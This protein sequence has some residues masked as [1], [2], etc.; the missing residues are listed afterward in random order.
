MARRDSIKISGHRGKAIGLWRIRHGSVEHLEGEIVGYERT[1]D[2]II[3]FISQDGLF[4]RC[5]MG[6]D[7]GCWMHAWVG[8]KPDQPKMD[9]LPKAMPRKR[10][11][12]TP[13]FDYDV[14]G[15]TEF[16]LQFMAENIQKK[17]GPGRPPKADS[18]ENAPID[19]RFGM[20]ER[21]DDLFDLTA[22]VSLGIGLEDG[23]YDNLHFEV[24]EL[25]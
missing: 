4:Q 23:D 1:A 24:A 14:E 2:G 6:T 11:D 20:D 18:E 21:P 17:R 13:C 5:K 16:D 9:D 7:P 8:E 19:Y 22:G 15:L 3:M 12:P 25:Y 10:V